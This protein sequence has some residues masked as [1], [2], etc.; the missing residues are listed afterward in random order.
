[1]ALSS[2]QELFCWV[3]CTS[4]AIA[5]FVLSHTFYVTTATYCYGLALLS[6]V[7]F[8]FVFRFRKKPVPEPKWL[9]VVANSG[10]FIL[11]VVCVL[12]VLGVA[13]WYE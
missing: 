4:L 7:G 5:L 9:S 6:V 13:T 3:T 2:K 11:S 10:L 1:L 12:Y 8:L